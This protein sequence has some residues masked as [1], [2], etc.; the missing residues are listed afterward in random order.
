[1]AAAKT[2]SPALLQRHLQGMHYPARRDDL[3]ARARDECE[4]VISTLRQLPDRDYDR[5]I[6]VSK[7]LGE[8]SKRYVEGASYPAQRGDLV[9]HARGQDADE[10]V[11]DALEA[12]PDRDYEGA[13]AVVD[14]IIVIVDTVDGDV[15]A[16][17]GV[18]P[19]VDTDTEED[20]Q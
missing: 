13:D 20:E 3:I 18:T 2:V 5:P 11:L 10:S 19:G 16:G 9:A 4:R 17:T 1:M 8:L 7:A 6:D 12:I 15:G 14:A